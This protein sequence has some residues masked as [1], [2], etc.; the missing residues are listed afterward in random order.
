MSAEEGGGRLV[1]PAP[2]KVNLALCIG[3]AREDGFHD[4]VSIFQA[5]DIRDTVTLTDRGTPEIRVT[6]SDTSLPCDER[7]TAHRAARLLRD[8]HAP[9]RGVD[10]HLAKAI[11]SEAGLGGGSSDAAAVLRGLS[12]LWG[13][14]LT[15]ERLLP[16]AAAVGSDVPFF[17]EGGCALV[18]GRGERVEPLPYALDAYLVVAKPAVGVSTARGYADLDVMRAGR[19]PEPCDEAVSAMCAAL[20]RGRVAGVAH[21]LRN[22]LEAPALAAHPEIARLKADLLAAGAEGALLSG[23]GSAVFGLFASAEAADECAA[24]LAARWP[25]VTVARPWR[26]V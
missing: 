9:G 25:W 6:A 11:P 24:S 21:A 7:N 20:E 16:P 5:I 19:E 26:S 3:A 18:R 12:S 13:L 8:A 2:A 1:V 17:L 23:S 10:I 14:G 4:L 15:S 22:D